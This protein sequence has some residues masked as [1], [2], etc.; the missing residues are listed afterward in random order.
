MRARG[1]QGRHLEESEIWYLIWALAEVA[2]EC[3][4][5]GERFSDPSLANIFMNDS[6]NIKLLTPF[7]LPDAF[8]PYADPLARE[9]YFSPE[10][11]QDRQLG[12]MYNETDPM[13][14]CSFAIGML[15][16]SL[17]LLKP[18]YF[19]YD[20][21][22]NQV[23]YPQLE[24]QLQLL[25]E[26]QFLSSEFNVYQLHSDAFQLLLRRLLAR[27]PAQRVS[28]S[29]VHEALKPFVAQISTL[30]PFEFKVPQPAPLSPARPSSPSPSS[31]ISLKSGKLRSQ[32]SSPP[33]SNSKPKQ[34]SPPLV[35]SKYVAEEP[36]VAGGP[37]F[38]R[39]I[40]ERLQK[41]RE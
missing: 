24:Q 3:A 21:D 20:Y 11:L 14:S 32:G 39:R 8:E 28:A 5:L 40:D 23:D 41:S 36:V 15:V 22:Q 26:V 19:L 6:G 12:R 4:R 1:E 33:A 16:L 38:L 29:Q 18:L 9:V 2:E 35:E 31:V 7:S 13:R 27:N 34:L 10:E 17:A 25:A 30:K 37:D